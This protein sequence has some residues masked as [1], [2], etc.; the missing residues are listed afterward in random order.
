LFRNQRDG[1]FEDVSSALAGF[2][3][4]SRR[5]AAFGDLNN[6]GKVDIVLLNVGEPPSLLLNET[7]DKNHRVLFKLI[8]TSSNRM[9]IGARV[10]I[11]TGKLTQVREVQAGGSYIS[12]NDPRLHFGLGGATTLDSVDIRWPKGKTETLRN[13]SADQLYT[14]V[15]GQGV[16]QKRALR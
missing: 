1:T 9:A 10:T 6:D 3:D 7:D 5:G 16:Q 4:S 12:Q 15:E 13:L 11:K 8:G 14:I 2:P